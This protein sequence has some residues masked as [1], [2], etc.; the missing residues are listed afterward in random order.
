MSKRDQPHDRYFRD[1]LQDLDIAKLFF[2]RHLS[3][4]I[5]EDLDWDT[6]T[7][8]DPSVTG[9]NNKQLRTD[10]VY[11]AL[12][13]DHTKE[14]VVLILNHQRDPDELLPIRAEEYT[15]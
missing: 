9:V 13:K 2:R 14:E 7:L 4:D 10:L 11:K 1:L 5:Q 6:L 3:K 8:T 12:T 15:L